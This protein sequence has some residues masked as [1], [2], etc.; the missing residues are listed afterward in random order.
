VADITKL[1]EK[2]QLTNS[3]KSI[4][5]LKFVRGGFFLNAV[6]WTILG[7]YSILR[8]G[9]KPDQSIMMQVVAILMFGN[10]GAFVFCGLTIGKK[11]RIFYLF[12]ILVLAV[13]ITLSITDEFGLLDLITMLVDLVILGFLLAGRKQLI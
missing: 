3:S 7:I 10:V 2:R 13:N 9:G 6:I 1:D 5:Y 4:P 12:S 11:S 8:T